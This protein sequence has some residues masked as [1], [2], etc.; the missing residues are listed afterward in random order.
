MEAIFAS[1]RI[2]S[3]QLFLSFGTLNL[4]RL[5]LLAC[6]VSEEKSS[7]HLCS[8]L[9]DVSFILPL[10]PFKILFITDSQKLDYDAP[11]VTS[12]RV[13][14]ASCLG[15]LH[16]LGL[17]VKSLHQ[18]YGK[19]WSLYL[20]ILFSPPIPPPSVRLMDTVR[21]GDKAVLSSPVS[22]FVHHLGQILFLFLR[23][24]CSSFDHLYSWVNSVQWAFFTK[25]RSFHLYEFCLVPL[26]FP[27][28][29]CTCFFLKILRYSHAGSL[30]VFACSLISV[31]SGPLVTGFPLANGSRFPVSS[32]VL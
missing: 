20:E 23:V 12:S 6:T 29:L 2:L 1:Y 28:L 11:W 15:K 24:L 18:I 30:N 17:C 8:S 26:L 5:C 3:R 4:M 19:I 13:C 22:L 27:S 16:F 9:C 21:H 7:F 32:C 10:T 25:Y 31:I 14:L